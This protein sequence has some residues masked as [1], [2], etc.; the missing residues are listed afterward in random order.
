MFEPMTN[1]EANARCEADKAHSFDRPGYYTPAIG[2]QRS[3]PH[4]RRDKWCPCSICQRPTRMTGTQK[5]DS[6]WEETKD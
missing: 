4:D 2:Q 5:C 6:C 1:A 3:D